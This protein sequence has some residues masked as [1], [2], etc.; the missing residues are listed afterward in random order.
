MP[1]VVLLERNPELKEF[2]FFIVSSKQDAASALKTALCKH[3]A[4]NLTRVKSSQ[5]FCVLGIPG[6]NATDGCSAPKMD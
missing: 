4:E 6:K 5:S 2:I 1:S 3:K